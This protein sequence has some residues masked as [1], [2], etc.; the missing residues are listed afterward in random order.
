[1]TMEDM[2][3]LMDEMR[4]KVKEFKK[5]KG[6]KDAFDELNKDFQKAF[7]I[8]RPPSMSDSIGGQAYRSVEKG[9]EKKSKVDGYISLKGGR[10][11]KTRFF[12]VLV[13]LLAIFFALPTY[14]ALAVKPIVL[15]CPLSTA[16]LYGW[17]ADKAITLAVEEI[18]AAGGVNVAGKKRPFKV[19]VIDT[20]DLEPGGAGK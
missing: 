19:E 15:G 17:D 9:G 12:A 5:P 8:N 16:F 6:I 3:D 1:M 14:S 4:E 10:V 13:I 7:Y 20:R 11:M 2:E 18:N